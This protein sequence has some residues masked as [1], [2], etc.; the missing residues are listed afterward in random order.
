MKSVIL[1]GATG[2]VGKQCLEFLLEEKWV[3][4]VTVFS[5]RNPGIDHKKLVT[6]IVD[7][8]EIEKYSKR[9]QGD[10]LISA[11]GT[12]IQKAGYDKDVFY[13]WDAQYPLNVAGLARE[14]GCRHFVFVSALGA[15]EKSPVFYSKVKGKIERLARETGFDKLDIFRPSMLLGDREEFRLLEKIASI[16]AKILKPLFIGPFKKS[17]PVEARDVAWAMVKAAEKDEPGERI[18]YYNH[19]MNVKNTG[20][21]VL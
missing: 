7:F 15:S 11:F 8:E 17:S 5:R 1:I 9:I 3:G 19:I 21:E 4:L 14:N 10:V 12:T 16:F 18:H 13:K 6:E 20:S 2:L